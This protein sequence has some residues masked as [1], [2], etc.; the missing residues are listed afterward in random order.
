[1]RRVGEKDLFGS[2]AEFGSR[3]ISI[4]SAFNKFVAVSRFLCWE[5]VHES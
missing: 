1:L 2:V 5:P 3:I 4:L